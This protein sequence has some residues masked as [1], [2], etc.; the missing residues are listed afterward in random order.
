MIKAGTILQ[1][2]ETIPYHTVCAGALAIAKSDEDQD[3][4]VEIQWLSQTKHLSLR[5]HDGGYYAEQF[6]PVTIESVQTQTG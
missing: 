4:I 5:Q 6:I 3:G 1:W 2:E